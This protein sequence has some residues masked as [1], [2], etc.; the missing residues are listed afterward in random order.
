MAPWSSL[1]NFRDRSS[2]AS[3]SRWGTLD[4]RHLC[5]QLAL[6]K[7]QWYMF[8]TFLPWQQYHLVGVNAL[9]WTACP[10][11]PFS[12]LGWWY[13]IRPRLPQWAAPNPGSGWFIEAVSGGLR[14]SY[15]AEESRWR[16]HITQN[17]VVSI[18]MG[19]KLQWPQNQFVAILLENTTKMIDRL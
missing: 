11:A 16:W 1:G 19:P 7:Q 17:S 4:H 18:I 8:L 3:F 14:F 10:L 12:V 13:A 2:N 6:K 9:S 5:R 15:V